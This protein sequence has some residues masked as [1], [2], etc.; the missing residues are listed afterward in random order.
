M[1]NAPAFVPLWLGQVITQVG[2][3]A[4]GLALGYYVFRETG[5][6]TA[7]ALLALSGYLP[8]LLFGSFAGVLADRWDRRRVLIISQLLQGV[9]V[10]ALLLAT[11][12]GWLWVAYAVMFTEL[13]LSLLALPAGAALLPTL[14]GAGRLGRANATLS[15]GTTVARLLGPPLGGL[16]VARSG[17]AG[18]VVFDALSFVLAA[19]CFT[20][21]PRPVPTAAPRP[22]GPPDS[23]LGSWRALAAEWRAGLRVIAG[24]PVILSLMAVLG[25]TSLGGTLVDPAYMP[26]VQGVLR[27]DATQV[28][29][30]SSVMGAS[31]LLGGLSAAW[32]VERFPLRR[33]I[34]GGTVLV[35]ALMLLTYTQ[36]S[37]PLM[38]VGVALMGLPMVVANVA[39]STLVQLATPDA[40]RGRVYGAL[41]TTNALVGVI[42][43]GG[44]ALVGAR[45]GPVALLT[46]AGSLTL[47]A[48]VVATRLPSRTEQVAPAGD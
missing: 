22:D 7:T 15:V 43:A 14:V 45:V 38:F 28:G 33:L 18:V 6:V 9:V 37:L 46:V 11:R 17:V 13:T 2:D 39:T 41:G 3:R 31:T 4:L 35:G 47:L 20:R 42:A 34:V 27:A 21:L 12:P 40:Y 29:L 48:G 44:A 24:H 10:L 36:A 30:L 1:L 32:A 16:L 19:L 23:L 5:S 25:L 26:F 8:G